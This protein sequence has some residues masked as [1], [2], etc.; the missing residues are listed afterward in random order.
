MIGRAAISYPWIFK[1]VK[2]FFAIGE[3]LVP[4]SN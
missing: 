2:H 1:E 3:L 4:L